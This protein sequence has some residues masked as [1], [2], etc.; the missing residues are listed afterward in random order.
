[1]PV[2]VPALLLVAVLTAGVTAAGAHQPASVRLVRPVENQ[3]VEGSKVEVQIA[4]VG[5]LDPAT[6]ELLLDGE[7]VDING[8]VPAKTLFTTHV[9]DPDS[10]STLTVKLPRTGSHELRVVAQ[11]DVDAPRADVV[12]RFRSQGAGGGGVPVAAVVVGLVALAAMGGAVAFRRSVASQT[13]A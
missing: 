13:E 3:V 6:F 9:V 10:Q 1:M 8:D 12:R 4:G 5:G 7:V 11:T 2:R